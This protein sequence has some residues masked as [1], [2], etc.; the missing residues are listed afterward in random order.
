MKRMSLRRIIA[1]SIVSALVVI[2]GGNVFSLMSSYPVIQEETNTAKKMPLFE[3]VNGEN[4]EQ[5]EYVYENGLMDGRTETYFGVN[6]N[7]TAAEMAYAAV[8]LY[9]TENFIA[10]SYNEFVPNSDEYIAKA[11]EY[12]IWTE[13]KNTPGDAVTRAE[14]GKILHKMAPEEKI[15]RYS[16]FIGMEKNPYYEAAL[17]LY[18]CGIALDKKIS[19]A[20]SP[21]L[22]LTKGE[23]VRLIFMIVNPEQRRT[24][25]ETDYYGLKTT[26]EGMLAEYDGDWSLY[27]EA[28]PSGEVISINSHQVYSAS[29]IKL[30]VA[31]T[32]YARINEGTLRE[33]ERIRDLLYK[34][35]TVSDND[36]WRELARIL[37]GGSYMSGMA[38]V[39]N[40]A[41]TGGFKDTGQFI[42]G[43]KQNYNFTSVD[44]CGLYLRRLL[45]G[46]IVAPAYSEKILD[47]L[48]QQRIRVKIP[49]VIPENVTVANKTGELEYIQGDAAVVYAPSGTYILAVIG[50]SLENTDTAQAQIRELSKA[51][52][53][54]LN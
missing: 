1:K 26:L 24:E 45:D 17:E 11:A 52:Y 44:D 33:T 53:D 15:K 18:E 23:A 43:E 20:Y 39:T 48:K 49:A 10:R 25:L 7:I 8:G 14:C 13:E 51:V 22:Y 46:E 12:G 9:E 19:A 28:Y 35:I 30:F 42:Q 2:I 31:Q 36:A 38:A 27:F 5:T 3:D 4:R 21:E 41:E 47:M 34:M 50:D 37:G 29:L 54:Y 6:E 40:T 16:G 32:V